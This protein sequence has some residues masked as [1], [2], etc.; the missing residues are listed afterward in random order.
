MS[1]ANADGRCLHG[2]TPGPSQRRLAKHESHLINVH[3]ALV[4]A[5]DTAEVGNEVTSNK[6]CQSQT[7]SLLVLGGHGVVFTK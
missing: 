7:T 5:P 4:T 1:D 3:V 2:G 6:Q